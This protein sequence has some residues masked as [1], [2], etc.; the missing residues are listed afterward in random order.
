METQG[1]RCACLCILEALHIRVSPWKVSKLPVLTAGESPPCIWC[2][3]RRMCH[4]EQPLK[5]KTRQRSTGWEIGP[6]AIANASKYKLHIKCIVLFLFPS[7]VKYS[8]NSCSSFSALSYVF[9]ACSSVSRLLSSRMESTDFGFKKSA[10][11][12]KVATWSRLIA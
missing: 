5:D 1:W 2:R 9:C 7:P 10:I 8:P 3:F 4:L 12:Y 6:R 11:G